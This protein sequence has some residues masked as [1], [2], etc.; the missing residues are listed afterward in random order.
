[1]DLGRAMRM[2]SDQGSRNVQQ[3]I[4]ERII[5]HYNLKTQKTTERS[6]G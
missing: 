5:S 4:L 3:I 1:L 2:S 6:V